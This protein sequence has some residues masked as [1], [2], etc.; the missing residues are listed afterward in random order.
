MKIAVIGSGIAGL[1]LT[2]FLDPEHEVT[3]YEKESWVGGNARTL[4]LVR[5]TGEV[6]Y[7]P[8]AQHVSPA[9]Y[10][11]FIRLLRVL[12]I[13]CHTGPRSMVVYRAGGG[14]PTLPP[15]PPRAGDLAGFLGPGASR[16]L[17]RIGRM[18]W[19]GGQ[20]DRRGDWTTTV[21]ELADR[22]RFD[23]RFRHDLLY[24]LLAIFA[25]P[26]VDAIEQVSARAALHFLVVR[27]LTALRTAARG[28]ELEGGMGSYVPALVRLFRRASL[29][30]PRTVQAIRRV[31][32]RLAVSE[33]DGS[34][35]TYDHV[36]LATPARDA[37]PLLA[38]LQGAEALRAA[39]AR[40]P[41][42]RTATRVH[43]DTR[44][45]PRDR[46]RWANV[47]M[48]IGY[49]SC[50][51]NMW[52][53]KARRDDLFKTLAGADSP[54]PAALHAEHIYHHT[55]LSPA[56]YRAQE[57]VWALQGQG[58]LSLVGAWL[59]GFECHESGVESAMRVAQ[60]LC[61]RSD[62]LALL[63]STP[64]EVVPVET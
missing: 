16:N 5:G 56:H 27:D 54:P 43:S 61:P 9:I 37:L 33:P 50:N 13:R 49:P 42:V 23:D 58:G 32:E 45:L 11:N 15:L 35:A 22:L 52:I 41:Y 21:K 7:D 31:G 3:L 1:S 12:G 24:P 47:N 10:P 36:V 60:R 30:Q 39:L 26:T 29:L 28:V 14:A 18:A 44:L 64:S 20:L 2:W 57:Q 63:R 55:F 48:E 6:R 46:T 38:P 17:L 4:T 62:N 53:G 34:S 25:G 40:F 59:V 8:A 51:L 19:A